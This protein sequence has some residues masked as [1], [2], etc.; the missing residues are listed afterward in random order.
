MR[1]FF[2]HVGLPGATRDFPKTVFSDVPIAVV[3]RAVPDAEPLKVPLLQRLHAAFPAGSFNCWG[4]PAGATSVIR[5]L[6]VGDVVLLV[7]S[8]TA[9]GRVS[10][11]CQVAAFWPQELRPLSLALW[12]EDKYPYIFFFRTEELALEWSEL[13]SQLGYSE[14]FDPRGNF[15]A[16]RPERLEGYGGS[17]AYVRDLRTRFAIVPPPF[18]ATS[19]EELRALPEREQA[20]VSDVTQALVALRDRSL[21]PEPRLTEGLDRTTAQ[22]TARP[23]NAAFALAVKRLYGYRCAM[24]DSSLQAPN[25]VAEVQAAHIF[26]KARDGSDDVR[27]GI[28]LCRLHHWAF[29]GGWLAISDDHIILVRDDLPE[30]HDY[31]PIRR[32]GGSTIRLPEDQTL[33]PHTLFLR[34]HRMLMGFTP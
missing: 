3:E 23:R 27:N 31:E 17:E 1:V 19:N 9:G 25:G 29:D 30:H 14:R 11:F 8:T 18:A 22:I 12:G 26:P 7:E 2:H 13:R 4:V 34:E 20:A 28:C 21:A 5:N 24:C 16:V 33:A 15:Y 10:A 6:A 32:F